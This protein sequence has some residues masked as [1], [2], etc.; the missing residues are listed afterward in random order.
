MAQ[1][2]RLM[3]AANEHDCEQNCVEDFETG[4]LVC[5]R[6]GMVVR[7][8]DN[9]DNYTQLDEGRMMNAMDHYVGNSLLNSATENMDYVSRKNK[10]LAYKINRGGKDFQGKK[11]RTTLNDPYKSGNIAGGKGVVMKEDPLTHEVSFK[12]NAYEKP[13]LTL[14]KE[15]A[16]SELARY[17]LSTPDL[18][19]VEQ[20][21]KRIVSRL[22]FAEM[23]EYGWIA[24]TL[25]AGVLKEK[26]R[27]AL[28][29]LYK[30]ME[31][32]RIKVLSRCN[33]ALE[34]ELKKPET[35]EK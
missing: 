8:P 14:I 30:L 5:I 4:E 22:F 35:A 18:A 21:C 25:N 28:Q 7:E 3:P 33:P 17:G 31:P 13:M 27:I 19:I 16:N 26:D 24:A 9:R 23:R 1:D 10:G 29:Q 20:E 6:C 32:I 15:R 12:F 2:L 11:V 34:A